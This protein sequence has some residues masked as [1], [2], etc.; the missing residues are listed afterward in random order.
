VKSGK[1]YRTAK[2]FFRNVHTSNWGKNLRCFFMMY[3]VADSFGVCCASIPAV[4][5]NR[6]SHSKASGGVK[7]QDQ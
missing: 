5:H 2:N 1:V 4:G 6:A 3:V 7:W